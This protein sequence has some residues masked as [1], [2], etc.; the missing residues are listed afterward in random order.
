MAKKL[1]ATASALLAAIQSAP[2]AREAILAA[3]TPETREE[4]LAEIERLRPLD[5]AELAELANLNDALA[6][7]EFA[8][9]L[10][11]RSNWVNVVLLSGKLP[12]YDTIRYEI[13]FDGAMSFTGVGLS[14]FSDKDG[15]VH[16]GGSCG[17]QDVT[18]A[19]R[20]VK[21]GS[22][23]PSTSV[24]KQAISAVVAE[25]KAAEKKAKPQGLAALKAAAAAAVVAKR[26]ANAL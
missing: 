23:Q 22:V 25:K 6:S 13:V 8:G 10:S 9:S 19:A 26:A 21:R 18:I 15:E 12:E 3:A 5:E 7:C 20:F 4:I 1:T 14:S 11:A 16:E 17:A 2:S 24:L